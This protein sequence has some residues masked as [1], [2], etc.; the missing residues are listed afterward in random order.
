MKSAS[1]VINMFFREWGH[2]F[3][4][5]E[6]TMRLSLSWA[7]FEDICREGLGVSRHS[8]LR[9]MECVERYPE[10]LLAHENIGLEGTKKPIE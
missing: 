1:F 6:E 8:L 5:D 3:I 7:G 2:Q 10:G 4:Y 9:G